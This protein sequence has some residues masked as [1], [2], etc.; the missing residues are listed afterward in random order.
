MGNNGNLG[1]NNAPSNRSASSIHEI[2]LLPDDA[3]HD[4]HS[5]A[6]WMIVIGYGR[7]CFQVYGSIRKSAVELYFRHLGI[8]RPSIG[9]VQLLD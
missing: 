3:T 9:N 4:L 5:I 6:D 2:D 8:Q 7:E 1:G